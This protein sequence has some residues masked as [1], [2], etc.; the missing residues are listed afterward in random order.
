MPSKRRNR[1]ILIFASRTVARRFG[2]WDYVTTSWTAARQHV[3][4]WQTYYIRGATP[5]EAAIIR[6]EEFAAAI[7]DALAHDRCAAIR[8]AITS[9]TTGRR[10]WPK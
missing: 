8:R 3:R 1:Y 10:A 2:Q 9:L 7:S 4:G 6:V 5:E